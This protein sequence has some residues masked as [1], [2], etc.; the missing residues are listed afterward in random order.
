VTTEPAPRRDDAERLEH[1][2]RLA[3]R[4]A[5][6]AQLPREL[7]LGRQPVSR[8]EAASGDRLLHLHDHVLERA[9][10]GDRLEGAVGNQRHDLSMVR[11]Y[12]TLQLGAPRGLT[13]RC[14]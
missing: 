9:A 13:P 11:P 10:A 3:H 7:A 8:A 4:R 6:D 5:A 1:A 14:A 2:Q 12:Q